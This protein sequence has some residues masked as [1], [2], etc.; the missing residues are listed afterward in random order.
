MRLRPAGRFDGDF[1]HVVGYRDYPVDQS[2]LPYRLLLFEGRRLGPMRGVDDTVYTGKAFRALCDEA[3]AGRIPA[4]G[5]T[6]FLHT[7]GIYGLFSFAAELAALPSP[8]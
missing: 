7:G 6:V 4:D 5:A 3:R 2:Q 8:R 1:A